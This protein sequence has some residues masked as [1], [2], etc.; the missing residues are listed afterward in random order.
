[1][2]QPPIDSLYYLKFKKLQL[3]FEDVQLKRIPRA[4]TAIANELSNLTSTPERT[5][6]VTFAYCARA[7]DSNSWPR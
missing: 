4:K 6:V 5:P 2:Q 7:N 1:M 3:S